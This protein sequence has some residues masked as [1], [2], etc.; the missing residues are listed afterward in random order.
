MMDDFFDGVVH[1]SRVMFA[2]TRGDGFIH[3][4]SSLPVNTGGCISALFRMPESLQASMFR[5]RVI[6]HRQSFG[7]DVAVVH[8]G[9]EFNVATHI[10]AIHGRFVLFCRPA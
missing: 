9:L 10:T 6:S 4:A 5:E 3:L 8:M 7:N 2:Y 1:N